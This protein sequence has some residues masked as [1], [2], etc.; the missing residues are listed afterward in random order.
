MLART[1]DRSPRGS[2]IDVPTGWIRMLDRDQVAGGLV[3][4]GETVA[5]F[6]FT[7]AGI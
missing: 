6:T 5:V 1:R 4:I 7:H 2:F 3:K